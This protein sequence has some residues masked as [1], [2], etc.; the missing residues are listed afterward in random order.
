MTMSAETLQN[1]NIAA[2]TLAS[3]SGL[4]G[5]YFVLFVIAIWS[6]YQKDNV[7][8]KRL[9]WVTVALFVDLLIHFISRSLQFSRARLQRDTDEEMRK[10]SIPL[11]FLGNITTT[12]AGLLSD[13]TLAWRFYIIWC[14]K[15]WALYIPAC[16]VILNA[17]LC[18]S[19]DFQHLSYYHNSEFYENTL[20]L[21]TTDIAVV[22]GWS[23]FVTNSMMTGGII[24]KIMSSHQRTLPTVR[25]GSA[26]V[27]TYVTALRAIIE[28]ALVTWIGILLC[29][30]G[31][32]GPTHGHITN[33][34]NMG[35]VIISI[36]P[37]F[38]GI[39]QSLI[40]ARLGLARE[41]RDIDASG[42]SYLSQSA[43]HLQGKAQTFA[44]FAN[45]TTHTD[46]Q[47][48]KVE[49]VDAKIEPV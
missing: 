23:M 39:S 31:F 40:T 46:A 29:E 49:E 22:W 2:I 48:A 16:A 34:L 30:I 9:R 15:K 33:N 21:V 19:A 41:V 26:R 13:G 8:S 42:A 12:F 44:V 5:V 36:I 47:E 45:V 10:W 17:L 24:Y 1:L 43:T 4:F 35:Y 32:L 3:L 11:T 37:V 28:S 20:L 27:N 7:S 6:T 38:F 25:R 14:R 18:W